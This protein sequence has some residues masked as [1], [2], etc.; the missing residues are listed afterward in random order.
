MRALLPHPP[1][2]VPVSSSFYP[3]SD[4]VAQEC[5]PVFSVLTDS[6]EKVFGETEPRQA[7]LVV[8]SHASAFR[9]EGLSLQLALRLHPDS[10]PDTAPAHRVAPAR[11]LEDPTAAI[12]VRVRCSAARARQPSR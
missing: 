6:L 8:A 4:A 1:G 5:S 7:G 10:A 3:R 12:E 2:L 9:G 11:P